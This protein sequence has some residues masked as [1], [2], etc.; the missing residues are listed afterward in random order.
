MRVRVRVRVSA[1]PA[2]ELRQRREALV[3]VGELGELEV[4]RQ[5]V[6]VLLLDLLGFVGWGRRWA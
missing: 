6:A 1:L 4:L 5:L 3:V 2:H